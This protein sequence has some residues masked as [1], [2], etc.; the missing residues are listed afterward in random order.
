MVKKGS[1]RERE[2][3]QHVNYV[4]EVAERMFANKGFFRVTMRELAEKA[5]FA[6]GTIY[7][8]FKGKRDLYDQLLER[9]VTQ[10][11]SLITE[12][13]SQEREPRRMVEKF[14]EG[15]LAF[16]HENLAFAR[17]YFAETRAPHLLGEPPLGLRLQRKYSLVVRDLT[18]I[19]KQGISQGTFVK[20]EPGAL[21]IAV[22]GITN[23]FALRW[24]RGSSP[25]SP[26]ADVEAAKQ[27]F[28]KGVLKGR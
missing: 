11:V 9:K 19:F 25:P 7:S 27:V 17:L 24:L 28:L 14:I 26:K 23:A 18:N 8:F 6:L 15:K 20:A 5:E 16:L 4:L 21:A 22:D 1:R 12:R 2:R 3:E 13:V 10:F